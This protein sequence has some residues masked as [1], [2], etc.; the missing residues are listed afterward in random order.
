MI[1]LCA[2][3]LAGLAA[4]TAAVAS[5]PA[6]ARHD[7]L[8]R[9][10]SRAA[11]PPATKTVVVDLSR[12]IASFVPASAL[13]AALDGH[14]YGATKTIYTPRNERAML[15]AGLGA[16]DY[17]LRTELG[18]AA[19]H[20]SPLG[21]W[22]DPA[23]HAGYWTSSSVPGPPF[24][25]SYGYDLPRRGDSA[26]QAN[27][28]GYSRLDDGSVKT[29]WKSNP[30]L[31]SYYTHESHP[32]WVLIDLGS[33]H[34][35]DALR[36][37]WGEP[38]AH[39][40]RVQWWQ[41]PH[42]LDQAPGRW[43]DFHPSAGAGRSRPAGDSAEIAGH[44]GMQTL[45]LARRPL[46]VRFVRVVL[47]GSSHTAPPG[48]RDVRDRLGYAIREL[49]LGR[50]EGG[51]LVDLVRHGEGG[52]TQTATF[53]SSTD[54]WHAAD[55]L[56]RNYEQP[57]FETVMGS[58][59]T[60]GLPVLVPVPV[61]YET[62]RNAV[63][64]LRYLRALHVP[65]GGVELGEEPDGQ[66]ASPEDY[67][68]LY[69]QFARAIHSYDPRLRLGGPGYQ[70]SIPDFIAWPN[71]HG[72]RSWTRRFVGYLRAHGALGQLGF[73]S[74]E[75]YPFDNGCRPV[76][77]QLARAAGMLAEVMHRQ[78]IDGLPSQ[79]PRII[80]EYGYSSYATSDE[81]EL[82]GAVLD[83]D[84]AAEFLALGGQRAYLYGYEPSELIEE[85]HGCSSWGNLT[86]LQSSPRDE[87]LAPVAAYWGT[88]LLTGSWAQ[89]GAQHNKML[90]T[91]ATGGAPVAAYALRRPDRRLAVLLLNK[92]PRSRH[93]VKVELSAGGRPRPL[94]GRVTLEQLSSAQYLWQ[95]AG[96]RGYPRRDRPP[97]RRLLASPP[98]ELELP[99]LS[100]TVLRT[101]GEHRS[102]ADA[103]QPEPG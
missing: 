54:P 94:T 28:T 85:L 74:F 88:R 80:T 11:H 92:D 10:R 63:A 65:I 76:G 100:I 81:V 61:L 91:S 15:S 93:A 43:R 29:F 19:W 25:A 102:L 62:P 41:G 9:P 66:Y 37:A 79:I 3:S 44:P 21:Q 77:P 52:H 2:A 13:G 82:A 31:D 36:I 53:A 34:P 70:T 8:P 38:Y 6:G 16:V 48:S 75:W 101:A 58:G 72:E 97:A 40:L 26:D 47:T 20:F 12:T 32:Q 78:A 23:Q 49:Y 69:L 84:I 99:P 45:R 4:P 56:D 50:L 89:P 95:A 83:A 18:V 7:A 55:N 60:R 64:E 96:E 71:A 73:F 46:S 24:L 1:V 30:Y 5:G 39:S 67:G 17:R 90:A 51:R 33:R 35:L 57:S 22:S 68:A 59:L 27:D 98:A 87:Q 14:E 86:L 103:V 42:A